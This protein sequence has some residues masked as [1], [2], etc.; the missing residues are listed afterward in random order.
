MTSNFRQISTK[1]LSKHSR[2]GDP[3]PWSA[4]RHL[5]A[6]Q[7]GAQQGAALRPIPADSRGQKVRAPTAIQR[8]AG[9]KHSFPHIREICFNLCLNFAARVRRRAGGGDPAGIGRTEGEAAGN[10]KSEKAQF[11]L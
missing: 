9:N 5:H 2:R 11:P 10:A 1:A 4:P 7:R 6:W 8:H 3:P